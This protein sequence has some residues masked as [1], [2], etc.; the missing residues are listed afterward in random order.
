MNFEEDL[1]KLEESGEIVEIKEGGSKYSYVV[2]ITKVENDCIEYERFLNILPA[3]YFRKPDKVIS[4]IMTAPIGN[5]LIIKIPEYNRKLA[6]AVIEA[7]DKRQ[8]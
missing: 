4:D 5:I 2:R 8:K 1:K 3:I 6:E 7:Y